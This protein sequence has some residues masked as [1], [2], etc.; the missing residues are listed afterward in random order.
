MLYLNV[1]YEDKDKAKS[2]GAKWDNKLK[3]WYVYD[4]R[5]YYKFQKWTDGD[6]VVTNN[7]FIIE[8]LENALN[9]QAQLFIKKALSK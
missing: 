1:P 6:Y 3:K 5:D 9:N 8:D 7:I 2:L 4:R